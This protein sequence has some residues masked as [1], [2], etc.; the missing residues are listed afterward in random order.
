MPVHSNVRIRPA[1]TDQRGDDMWNASCKAGRE[2]GPERGQ[3][4]EPFGEPFAEFNERRRGQLSFDEGLPEYGFRILDHYSRERKSPAPATVMATQGSRKSQH[5]QVP[6]PIVA[7]QH[8]ML[9]SCSSC[10]T[11]T[12]SH[13]YHTCTCHASSPVRI[14]NAYTSRHV[15]CPL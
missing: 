6:H 1:R 4:G 7:L 5:S 15:S 2:R 11:L 12:L 13:S 8:R 10:P 14:E 9:L 3:F